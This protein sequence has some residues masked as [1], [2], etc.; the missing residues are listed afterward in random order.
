MRIALIAIRKRM[1]V[2]MHRLPHLLWLIFCYLVLAPL[3]LL[4]QWLLGR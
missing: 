3:A 2:D 4:L 1:A